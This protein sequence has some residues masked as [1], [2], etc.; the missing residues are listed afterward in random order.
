L[1]RVVLDTNVTVAAL[2]WKG[3]PRVVYDLIR[4]R[5]LAILIS[6]DMEAELIRVLGYVKFGLLPKEIRPIVMNIRGNAELIEIKSRVSLI[7]ILPL[8][9]AYP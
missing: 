5:K 4:E 1:K 7:R 2:F 3:Y 8:P 6:K 9:S